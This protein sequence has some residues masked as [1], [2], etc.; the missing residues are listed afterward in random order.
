MG[1]IHAHSFNA[2]RTNTLHELPFVVRRPAQIIDRVDLPLLLCERFPRSCRP[3][4]FDRRRVAVRNK[5]TGVG[6]TAPTTTRASPAVPFG[7]APTPQ[8]RRT[9]GLPKN[10]W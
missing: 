9:G 2:R 8:C 5:T 6:D 7:V 3:S 1:D 10:A 4:D